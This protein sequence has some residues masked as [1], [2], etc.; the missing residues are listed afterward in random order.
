M[1]Q[2]MCPH[3]A[4]RTMVGRADV[5]VGWVP[6]YRNA[7]PSCGIVSRN[8]TGEDLHRPAEPEGKSVPRFQD[9]TGLTGAVSVFHTRTQQ[10]RAL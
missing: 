5:E 1:Q 6:E 10:V 9:S 8:W 3:L 4:R 2:S 7:G